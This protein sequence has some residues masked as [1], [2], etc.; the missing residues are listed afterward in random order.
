[1]KRRLISLLLCLCILFPMQILPAMAIEEQK[2]SAGTT[3]EPVEEPKQ[4]ETAA[5]DDD[6][7]LPLAEEEMQDASPVPV[8]KANVPYNSVSNTQ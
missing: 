7:S 4:K 5:F 1:M 3:A 8:G 6:A 2:E